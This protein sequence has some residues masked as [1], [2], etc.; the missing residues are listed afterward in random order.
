MLSL[1]QCWVMYIS[2]DESADAQEVQGHKS[3]LCQSGWIRNNSSWLCAFF[4]FCSS[5]FF[6]NKWV[7]FSEFAIGLMNTKSRAWTILPWKVF[8]SSLLI[9]ILSQS[10][11]MHRCLQMHSGL[12]NV[13]MPEGLLL[14]L[15]MM[16]MVESSCMTQSKWFD[17]SLWIFPTTDYFG[18]SL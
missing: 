15:L 4:F 18:T 17:P 1:A 2:E 9:S 11:W 8:P 16:G 5:G 3:H 13:S 14:L 12:Q 10:D 6:Q 7:R